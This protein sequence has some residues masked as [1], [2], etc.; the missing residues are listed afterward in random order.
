MAIRVPAWLLTILAL[1]ASPVLAHHISGKVYCDQD[2]DGAIDVPGDSPISGVTVRATSIDVSPGQQFSDGT[3]GSG[4]YSIGLPG[5]TDRYTVELI[6]LAGGLTVVLPV[7]GTHTVQIVTGTSQ[8]HKDNVNFLVQGCAPQPTTTTTSTTTTTTSTTT[9]T[10]PTTTTTTST[11]TT[12]RPTTTTTTTSTTTTSTTTTTTTVATTTTTTLAVCD[13]AGFPFLG[14]REV[15]VNNDAS[16]GGSLGTNDAGGRARLG[17][18]VVMADGTRIA[19]DLVSIGGGSSVYDVRAN[20]LQVGP[21]VVVRGTSALATLPL[22]APCT[23]PPFTCGVTPVQ[24]QVGETA[25]PLPPGAYGRLRVLNGA[26]L[27]LAPGEFT[28]CDVKLG[29]NAV[30]ETLGPVTINVQGNF[31]IGT[32]STVAPATGT[33]P[34]LVN[35]AGKAVRLSQSAVGNIA[36]VAPFARISFGRDAR[37]LGCFCTDRAKSDKHITLE[38]PLP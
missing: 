32:A 4:F 3:D 24:V 23:L 7:G 37:L 22:A 16:V 15:K 2:W 33:A 31:I 35:V 38:C 9:T 28:F 27:L 13:C 21:E 19:G 26:K 36:V 5:R 14:A 30:I 11:T 20:T 17:K 6:G 8:D 10:R 12:T 29:R 34:V 18:D 25:G 1:S